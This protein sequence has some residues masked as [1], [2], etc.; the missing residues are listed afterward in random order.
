MKIRLRT[1]VIVWL[2]GAV[3]LFLYPPIQ[4]IAH[5][6][7]VDPDVVGPG[8][9]TQPEPDV[10][11][12]AREA[13][14]RWKVPHLRASWARTS[15]T[16]RVYEARLLAQLGLWTV[17]V[18]ALAVV[19]GRAARWPG[20]TGTAIRWAA[21]VAAGFASANVGLAVLLGHP[22][23]ESL[24]RLVADG[25]VGPAAE[26]TWDNL[27]RWGYG[28]M[29]P[30]AILAWGLGALPGYL[31][32]SEAGRDWAKEGSPSWAKG[33]RQWPRGH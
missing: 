4:G 28:F 17:M 3:G 24:G 19:G 11:F 1:A 2:I 9:L 33:A 30:Y 26:L 18:A 32:R 27:F 22:I 6:D 10:V 8:E 29:L 21:L 13:V 16:F 25:Q 5:T 20:P 12:D 23:L 14:W 7:P 31:R 15:C